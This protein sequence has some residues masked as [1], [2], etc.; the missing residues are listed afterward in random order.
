MVL[1]IFQTILLEKY[2]K[3][4][5]SRRLIAVPF[6]MLLEV[7]LHLSWSVIHFLFALPY[8]VP[9]PEKLENASDIKN[10]P[11]S[12][13]PVLFMLAGMILAWFGQPYGFRGVAFIFVSYFAPGTKLLNIEELTSIMKISFFT[14]Y[15]ASTFIN[16]VLCVIQIRR[17]RMNVPLLFLS[18]GTS[19]M[20]FAAIYFLS[21]QM[22]PFLMLSDSLTEK[23]TRFREKIKSLLGYAKVP[24]NRSTRFVLITVLVMAFA[25]IGT[26][27]GSDIL[28]WETEKDRFIMEA[29][30]YIKKDSGRNDSKIFTEF[31]FGSH[32]ILYDA[33]RVYMNAK[34]EPKLEF[35]N[36]N[37]DILTEYYNLFTIWR[38]KTT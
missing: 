32:F 19:L 33:G 36:G 14:R 24:E 9:L 25:V 8:L 30:D 37:K 29:I 3:D 31:S 34:T 23:E 38:G 2:K 7:N 27:W 15:F 26:C 10:M 20:S 4:G 16:I 21:L 18:M 11:Q 17:K 35:I 28:E 5:I 22:I 6:I 1:L 12:R 13:L